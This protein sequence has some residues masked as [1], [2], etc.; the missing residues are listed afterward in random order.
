[1]S[2]RSRLEAADR[3]A[4]GEVTQVAVAAEDASRVQPPA[5]DEDPSMPGIPTVA[6]PTTGL[7]PVE[8]PVA[9]VVPAEHRR[10][11]SVSPRSRLSRPWHCP[12]CGMNTS[13]RMT[14]ASR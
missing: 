10:R 9:P 4:K 7:A 8:V 12:N 3:L 13:R 1:M 11:S 14:A 2:V 5:F 6:A